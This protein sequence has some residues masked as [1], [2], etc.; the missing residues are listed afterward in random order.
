MEQGINGLSL[1]KSF[2][3]LGR[4][5]GRVKGYIDAQGNGLPQVAKGHDQHGEIS[6]NWAQKFQ[7]LN[8]QED[9]C[10][11]EGQVK[12]VEGEGVALNGDVDLRAGG[13]AV[14]DATA[15]NHEAKCDC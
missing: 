12:K 14:E 1:G 10:T 4:G 3:L 9:I 8:P 6:G 15:T 11:I 2:D 7:A 13:V 5:S